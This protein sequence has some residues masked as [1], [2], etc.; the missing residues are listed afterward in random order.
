MTPLEKPTKTRLKSADQA[1]NHV[2]AAV[3]T[4]MKYFLYF[5]CTFKL[6]N[7]HVKAL[8]VSKWP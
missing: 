2:E 4:P 8:D 3:V 7:I 1:R 6:D 5:S